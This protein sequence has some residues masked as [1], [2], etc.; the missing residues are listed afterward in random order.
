MMFNFPPKIHVLR[1]IK[2]Q[3]TMLGFQY[4]NNSYVLGLMRDRDA[5]YI[6]RMITDNVIGLIENFT[7]NYPGENFDSDKSVLLLHDKVQLTITKEESVQYDWIIESVDTH[8]ILTYP[9]QRYIGLI[10]PTEQTNE[11]PHIL[12]YNSIVIEPIF[13]PRTFKIEI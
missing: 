8:E 7:P 3:G 9:R 5:M 4:K 2:N 13:D 1:N 11:T 6:T 12:E 10:M